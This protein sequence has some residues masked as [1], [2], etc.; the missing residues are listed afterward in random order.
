M[1]GLITR[2]RAR[3]QRD[4]IVDA[5]GLVNQGTGA[6]A[7]AIWTAMATDE[8]GVHRFAGSSTR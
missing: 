2:S 8:P 6:M 5:S 4:T 1:P 7:F 3:S